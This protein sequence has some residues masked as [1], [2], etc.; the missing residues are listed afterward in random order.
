MTRGRLDGKVA[1]ISG[2]AAGM[3]AVEARLFAGE[4]ARVVVS[5]VQD[6]LGRSVTAEL[7]DQAVYAHLDVTRDDDWRAAVAVAEEQFGR[8]DILVNNAGI[9]IA[10]H[11]ML[12]TTETDH[13]RVLEVNLNGT[14]R[15]I[16]AAAPALQ[17]AGGGS[18]VNISSI[19]G[20]AGIGG[21]TSYATSKFG[22]TGLTKSAALELGRLGIRVNAVHPGII[23]TSM[24]D[25]ASPDILDRLNSYVSLQP[26]P[27]M[28]APEEVAHTVLFLASDEASYVTGASIVVDGGHLAGPH[29]RLDFADR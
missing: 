9:G 25:Q 17:R 27:R 21:M 24:L 13:A 15:G 26:I 8:L 18:I 22:V 20:L 10:P 5:D 12:T 11:S 4:G 6:A 1:L 29:R 2:A 7:A 16:R 19:D 23:A 14:W 3:G 28:G